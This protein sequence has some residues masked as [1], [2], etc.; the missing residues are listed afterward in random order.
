MFT[1]VATIYLV[2]FAVIEIGCRRAGIDPEV[3][4]R[5]VHL[6]CGLSIAILPLVLPYTGIALLGVIFTLVMLVS[7]SLRLLGSIH[8]VRRSTLGEA[9]MPLGAS[10]TALVVPHMPLFACCMCVLAICDVAAG[11]CGATL[12][13]PRL[14]AVAGSK[15][16][17]GSAACLLSA[18]FVVLFFAP[19]AGLALLPALGVA[20]MA[21]FVE[22]LSP[23]GLDNLL[24]PLSVAGALF[25]GV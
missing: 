6:V 8:R 4:R 15:T 23:R 13:G 17:A 19:A 3:S 1:L 18:A 12:R 22:A 7:R 16:I 11:V 2:T 9:Y 25:C 21:T 10:I 20:A 14:G 24:I 5:V